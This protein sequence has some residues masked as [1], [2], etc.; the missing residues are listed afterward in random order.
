[1]FRDGYIGVSKNATR[2]FEQHYKYAKYNMHPNTHLAYAIK[3]YGW[4]NLVK[5]VIIEADDDYCYDMEKKLRPSSS[6]GWNIQSGGDKPPYDV[7]IPKEVRVQASI[8]REATIAQKRADNCEYDAII[9]QKRS[10][11]TKHR[12]DKAI[13]LKAQK[14]IKEFRENPEYD[15]MYR[16]SKRKAGIISNEKRPKIMHE[17]NGEFKSLTE[18]CNQ[19]GISKEL[20]YYRMKKNNMSFYDALNT[21]VRNKRG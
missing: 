14:T 19:Y 6:I 16:E 15:K 13:S 21:K 11:A 5:K 20:V 17:L 3:K 9:R 10:D 1:M 7:E 12:N 8:K 18:W 4:D 2:R